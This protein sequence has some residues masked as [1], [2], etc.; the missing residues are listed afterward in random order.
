MEL[1]G[2]RRRQRPQTREEPCDA[3]NTL[4]RNVHVS[5]RQPDKSICSHHYLMT[6]RLSPGE[7][8]TVIQGESD[9]RGVWQTDKGQERQRRVIKNTDGLLSLEL[10]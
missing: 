1:S 3:M 8:Q 9:R 7:Q 5:L 4:S 6:R 10:E 2:V